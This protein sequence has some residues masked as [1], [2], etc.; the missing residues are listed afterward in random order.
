ME[1][2]M[3]KRLLFLALVLALVAGLG[4]CGDP[5]VKLPPVLEV[6]YLPLD[7][8]VDVALNVP[9]EIYFSDEVVPASVTAQSVLLERDDVTA[10]ACGSDWTAVGWEAGVD[11]NQAKRV[12][13]GNDK[14][15]LVAER[16]YRIVLTTDVKGV[17]F[18][19]MMDL[20][21]QGR[22]G[23]AAEAIFMTGQD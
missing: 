8:A 6:I 1:A 9:V 16:C 21:M 23:V 7:G 13:I 17:E 22:E 11:P 20:G 4:A 10:G 14:N 5:I 3:R 19:H 12:R 2:G 15:E 18:G